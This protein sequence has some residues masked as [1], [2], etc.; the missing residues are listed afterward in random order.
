MT[1]ICEISERRD[2]GSDVLQTCAISILRPLGL[3]GFNTL[4]VFGLV[5]YSSD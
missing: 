5:F 3:H 1:L 2:L 4:F